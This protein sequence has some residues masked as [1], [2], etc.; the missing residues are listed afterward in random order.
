MAKMSAKNAVINI[1]DST[2]TPQNV[3][4]DC[5]SFDIKQDAGKNEVTGFGDG[6]K[7]YI[8]GMPVTEISFDFLW[9]SSTTSGAQSVLKGIYNSVS[10]KTVSIKPDTGGLTLS[11]EFML[12]NLPAAGKPDGNL[13]LGKVT[14]S[15]YGSTAPAWA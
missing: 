14:F 2:G 13:Q 12:D 9:N 7:N 5:V 6:T 15:V 8:P 10:S 1:D 11:G 3:S 4:A